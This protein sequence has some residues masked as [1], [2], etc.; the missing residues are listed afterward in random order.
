MNNKPAESSIRCVLD[1]GNQAKHDIDIFSPIPFPNI[2][3]IL[4]F[5]FLQSLQFF[6][7]L[8]L[9][10]HNDAR[11]AQMMPN[12]PKSTYIAVTAAYKTK[13]RKP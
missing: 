1:R 5:V 11:G 7:R 8:L 4:S 12:S 6:C 9:L 13:R 3:L 2:G 10:P